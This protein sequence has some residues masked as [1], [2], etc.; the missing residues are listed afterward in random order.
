MRK[1]I[2]ATVLFVTFAMAVSAQSKS[3]EVLQA[4][5]NLFTPWNDSL[6]TE[7]G[8][9][10]GLNGA[11][12]YE[13]EKPHTFTWGGKLLGRNVWS[14]VITVRRNKDNQTSSLDV[15]V[16]AATGYAQLW[17][18]R[19]NGVSMAGKTVGEAFTALDHWGYNP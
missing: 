16:N 17:S 4:A 19:I 11:V 5:K 14:V 10:A 15:F 3:Q 6:K 12:T 1:A 13:V 9:I 8:Q 7:L 18:M 2:T